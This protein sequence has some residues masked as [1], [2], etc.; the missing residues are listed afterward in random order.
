MW[1]VKRLIIELLMVIVLEVQGE[2]EEI[3]ITKCKLAAE[4][5]LNNYFVKDI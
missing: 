5:V 2:P 1:I 4:K 3:A